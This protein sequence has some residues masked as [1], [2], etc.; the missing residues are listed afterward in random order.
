L[1][2]AVL[3]FF[4]VFLGIAKALPTWP[5][6]LGLLF[7]VS[8]FFTA[9]YW[10]LFAVMGR[11]TPGVVLARNAIRGNRLEEKLRDSQARFR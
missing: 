5:V 10:C 2:S 1:F 3:T 11:G 7:G 4:C 9:L 8:G 6:F